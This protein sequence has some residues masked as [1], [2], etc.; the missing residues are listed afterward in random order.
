MAVGTVMYARLVAVPAVIDATNKWL[1]VP[2]KCT[3][4]RSRLLESCCTT[5]P[6]IWVACASGVSNFASTSKFVFADA[7]SSR[8]AWFAPVQRS[9]RLPA[10]NEMS[11]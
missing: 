4:N 3:S 2:L 7:C 10:G 6:S 9:W 1:S 5:M 8:G 11:A